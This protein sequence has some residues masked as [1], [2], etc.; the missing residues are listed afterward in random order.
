MLASIIMTFAPSPIFSSEDCL[1]LSVLGGDNPLCATGPKK[2]L[3][4]D[5]ARFYYNLQPFLCIGAK[6]KGIMKPPFMF[7]ESLIRLKVE[8]SNRTVCANCKLSLSQNWM[9]PA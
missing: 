4:S 6:M 3:T 9:K 7:L 1:H 5:N 8:L 2:A